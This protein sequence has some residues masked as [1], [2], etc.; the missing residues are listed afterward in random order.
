M[1]AV[2]WGC[3]TVME[4]WCKCVSPAMVRTGKARP[5]ERVETVGNRPLF[6]GLDALWLRFT[7]DTGPDPFDATNAHIAVGDD[8]RASVQTQTDLQGASTFRAPMEDGYPLLPD[9]VTDL[10]ADVNFMSE[11]GDEIAF[12]SIFGPGEAV[13]HWRELGVVNAA[14][15]GIMLNRKP[16]DYGDKLTDETRRLTVYL[17]LYGTEGDTANSPDG[18]PSLP[19]TFG[20]T[21]FPPINPTCTCAGN[22]AIFPGM[23]ILVAENNGGDPIETGFKAAFV[24]R[25]PGT[26]TVWDVT[27]DPSGDMTWDVYKNG[28][29]VVSP[30]VSGDDLASDTFVNIPVLPGD[31]FKVFASGTPTT[32]ASSLVLTI[33]NRADHVRQIPW[34]DRTPDESDIPL[35]VKGRF[36]ARFNGTITAWDAVSSGDD[37][38]TISWT[39]RQ[40][41]ADLLV[42]TGLTTGDPLY[43][44]ITET[45]CVDGD[46]FEFEVTACSGVSF[47]WIAVKVE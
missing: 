17:R 35:G 20:G 22:N 8:G 26:I 19:G 4:R 14:S 24:T 11:Q 40:N 28:V 42:A 16:V 2:A 12:R 27:A 45:P 15:D 44:P 34:A 36:V 37:G 25:F 41:G 30:A 1:G 23:Q 38:G 33:E 21:T 10:P 3:R 6:L 47:S 46:V 5:L 7:G 43:G 39:I 9:G 32:Q 13:F 31:L 29:L 18:Q